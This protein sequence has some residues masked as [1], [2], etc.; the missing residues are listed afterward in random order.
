MGAGRRGEAEE[1]D[2]V[3]VQAWT[4]R[5]LASVPVLLGALVLVFLIMQV[6]PGDRVDKIVDVT[7]TSPKQVSQLRQ[8][9]GLD[10]P[11]HEQ[12]AGYIAGL[13]RGDFGTSLIDGRAVLPMILAA[14]PATLA[15]T[16]VSSAIAVAVGIPLG[17]LSALRQGSLI[18]KIA[19]V[20][21]LF[22][23]S[24]PS[25]WVGILLILLF[26]NTLRWLPSM[27]SAGAQSLVLPSVALGIVG[28]G[29]IVR[30]VRNTM[31]DTLGEPY[32]DAL[33]ARGLTERKVVYRHALRNAMI[34]AM[35]MIGL[36]TAEM[37]GGSVVIETVFARQ[38]V[39]RIAADAI[40]GQDLPVVQAVVLLAALTYIGINLLIDMLY[41]LIDPRLRRQLAV[42][43]KQ[44]V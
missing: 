33:R 9:L 27:G 38:G 17:V 6:L 2:R 39:G 10:R 30:I 11:I 18:D 21:G 3:M 24:M 16:L 7:Q 4:G 31:L 12:F 8:E 1:H 15:L 25:F 20:V 5:L 14:L 13:A 35:T 43:G 19:R 29:F 23:I 41:P 44:P 22:G 42:T 26:A 40:T 37:L 34:P 32:I 28:A 36:M